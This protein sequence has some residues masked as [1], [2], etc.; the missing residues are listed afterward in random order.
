VRPRLA[1]AIA[2]TL[3][4]PLLMWPLFEKRA[5]A[6][7]A[8][9]LSPAITLVRDPYLHQTSDAGVVIVWATREPGPASVDYWTGAETPSIAVA[10]TGFYQSATTGI[11]DYYQHEATL[12]G[13]RAATTYQY[14]LRVGGVDATPGVV[15]RFR[16]APS[17]GT[18]A[19]RLVVLGDT[20]TGLTAQGQI[21]GLVGTETFDLALHTGDVAYSSGTFAEFEANFFP[22]YRGW[23]R[24]RP[25]FPS[26]GNHDDET[27]EAAPYK[28]LFALA[29]NGWNAAYPDHRERYYSFDYGPVHFAALDTELAFRS[30]SR[31]EEQLAW[32]DA[33][34]QAAQ[35]QRWRIVFFHRPPYSAGG[36]H[37]SEV[38]VREAFGPVLEQ[39]GVQIALSGHEHDYERTVPWRESQDAAHQAVTYFVTGGGGAAL[40]PAGQASWTALSRSAHHYLR[41]TI[42]PTEAAV[43][44]VG[45]NGMVFDRFLLDLNAQSIDVLPPTVSITWPADGGVLSGVETVEV[46]AADDVRVEKV[47][48]WVDGQLRAIDLTAPYSFSL[49]TRTLADGS[50]TLEARAYDIDG[51]RAGARHNVT[52]LN[53]IAP[54]E[55]VLAATADAYVRAGSYASSSFGSSPELVS[56]ANGTASYQRESYLKFDLTT[57]ATVGRATLRLFGRLSDARATNVQTG[58][59]SVGVTT[60][61]ENTLT[62][63]NKPA[64]G[65]TPVGGLTVVNTIE[66]WYDVDVTAFVRAEKDAGRNV[67]GLALKGVTDSLPYTSFNSKEAAV[68]H[69]ELVVTP[70]IT[71][72]ATADAYVRAG[73]YASSNFG[74]ATELVSKANSAAGYQRESYLKF[75][76]AKVS[77]IGKATLRLRGRLS[78]TRNTDVQTGVYSVTA[79]SWSEP[80]LTWNNKPAAGMS[81]IGV[82]TV[83]NTAAAWYEVDITAFVRAEKQAG[84]SVIA[85]ALKN[86]FESLPYTSFNSREAAASRPEL[87][88]R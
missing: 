69:P 1:I 27:G 70:I 47:D 40:Y 61:N 16:T 62:W 28:S 57:V 55:I 21:A 30:I 59:Y 13:L 19:V 48:L 15:D 49:D 43:E 74:S 52:V 71:L 11:G 77:T 66:G 9:I 14:D 63:N 75:H 7:R 32:L 60:W 50:R 51:K 20:G 68:N 35:T 67:I 31:R 24:S 72:S 87:V 78:D 29:G 4:T 22:Y 65:M 5:A 44:A 84:R 12:S 2:L 39:H 41:A 8:A 38:E 3:T 56:K 18:G 33:D 45:V 64:S 82:F 58:V 46:A 83:V 80:T 34:L 10:D 37:G 88:V 85:I 54:G 79:T 17:R 81:P 73:S 86:L 6:A 42:T 53:Q 76:L 36:G 25:I 23:L 26:I